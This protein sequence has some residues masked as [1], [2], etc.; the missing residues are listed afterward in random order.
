MKPT[1][2]RPSR[3]WLWFAAACVLQVIV[4][5]A[6]ITFASKHRVAEVPLAP[7]RPR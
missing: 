6:W 2:G 4:W 3:L 5:G 7:A 1:D